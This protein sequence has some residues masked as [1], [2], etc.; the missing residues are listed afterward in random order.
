MLSPL[1]DVNPVPYGDELA[2]NVNADDNR[3]SIPL[4]VSAAVYFGIT[5]KKAR[6]LAS[7]ILAIV[8]ENWEAIA[9]EY[10]LTHTQIEDMRPAFS[11][12]YELC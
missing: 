12:C 8:R 9:K 10:H 1:Y 2:L 6:E 3:I 7:D 11:A 4:A 5:E